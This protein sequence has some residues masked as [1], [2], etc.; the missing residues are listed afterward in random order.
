[1]LELKILIA[2]KT[3]QQTPLKLASYKKKVK[4]TQSCLIL[5]NPTDCIVHEIL[6]ASILEWVPFCRG[7]SQ[8]RIEPRSSA[9]QVDSL[10]A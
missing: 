2:S 7:S 6:Q 8:T 4:V 9:L 3:D 10:P 5:C 1:M